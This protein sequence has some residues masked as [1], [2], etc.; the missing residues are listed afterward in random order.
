MACGSL[1]LVCALVFGVGG[2]VSLVAMLLGILTWSLV[3]G[4]VA[5][6]EGYVERVECSSW[7]QAVRL[8]LRI[9]AGWT[10]LGCVGMIAGLVI[11]WIAGLNLMVLPD[12]WA[13]M[14]AV[15]VG[16]GIWNGFSEAMDGVPHGFGAVYLT[17][18]MQ[19]AWVLFSIG[20]LAVVIHGIRKLRRVSVDAGQVDA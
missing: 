1:S 15:H 13:G 2:G 5:A 19:G 10:L 7:E 6:T 8:A 17:T 12:F 16:Q 20:V 4:V 11:P 14:V 9:R 3:C 18:L